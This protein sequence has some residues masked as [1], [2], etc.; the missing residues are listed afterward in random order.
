M[1]ID[2][3]IQLA[4]RRWARERARRV[5]AVRHRRADVPAQ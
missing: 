3:V 4:R 1:Q 2:R 5:G